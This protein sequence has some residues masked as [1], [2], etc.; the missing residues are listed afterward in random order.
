MSTN[1]VDV[2]VAERLNIDIRDEERLLKRSSSMCPNYEHITIF[3]FDDTLLPSSWLI[4]V[5]QLRGELSDK[6]KE[7]MHKL[8]ESAYVLLSTALR[9][10]SVIIITNAEVGWIRSSCSMF[11]P[12]FHS[13]LE[14]V[15]IVSARSRYEEKYPYD[16]G[17][18]KELT[19]RDEIEKLR[20]ED[21]FISLLSIGDSLYERNAALLYGS[22]N[23]YSIV[24]SI[25][26]I[27][28]PT[29]GQLITQQRLICNAL[30]SMIQSREKLD[31]KLSVEVSI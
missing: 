21:S 1:S 27:D 10:S 5:L 22:T 9:F 8:D 7:E 18:W 3:D 26:M 25:K 14:S 17:K 2:P 20:K 29:P 4:Q 13:L 16:S 23:K 31:L 24:K 11:M 12:L 19:F 6:M 28:L 30:P 15:I